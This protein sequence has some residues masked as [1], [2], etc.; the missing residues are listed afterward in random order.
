MGRPHRPGVLDRMWRGNIA[1]GVVESL[2]LPS[3]DDMRA[4]LSELFRLGA[5]GRLVPDLAGRPIDPGRRADLAEAMVGDAPAATDPAEAV[6]A[7]IESRT[8]GGRPPVPALCLGV[9]GAR[10]AYVHDHEFCDGGTLAR[11]LL[12]IHAFARTG[13]LPDWAEAPT[14]G[15]PLARA[16]A[17]TFA[18]PARLPALVAARREARR[19]GGDWSWLGPQVRDPKRGLAV[20]DIAAADRSWIEADCRQRWPEVTGAVLTL[21]LVRAALREVGLIDRDEVGLVVDLRRYL[22]RK[23]RSHVQ[24]NFIAGLNVSLPM[25]DTPSH[26]QRR[27]T[28]VLGSG[29]PL[30]ATTLSALK[31]VLARDSQPGAGLRRFAGHPYAHVYMGS[32][33]GG[34]NGEEMPWAQGIRRMASWTNPAGLSGVTGVVTQLAGAWQVSLSHYVNDDAGPRVQEAAGLLAHDAVELWRNL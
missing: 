21:A 10:L 30:A 23:D 15:W 16:L 20:A 17:H 9:T 12:G 8:Q 26:L 31:F 6:I 7:F 22:P 5:A 32:R 28:A 18:S 4:A 2:D 14:V 3:V 13:A 29:R 19:H 11:V 1:A 27:V 34:L 33:V 24:G 25:S